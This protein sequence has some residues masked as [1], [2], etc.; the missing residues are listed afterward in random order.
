MA[1]GSIKIAIEV[2]GKEVKIASREL[3]KLEDAG[4]DSSKGIKAAE[5]SM[6]SLADS[7][8]DA[9]KNIKG[10]SDNLGGVS[11]NSKKASGDIKKFATALGLV[12]IGVAAFNTLKS[13]MDDAISRFDTLNKFPKV[14]Q[15]LGV[16][17]EDSERA[18]SKLSDGIDGLPTKL[19]EISSTA[20]RMYTS[21]GDMDKATDSALALNN[22]LLGSG[23]S[24]A[25]AQRGTEQYLKALQTGKMEMDT[26][27]SL[28]E[29]MD[30]GLIKIAEGFGFAGKSAKQ[31]LY[32]ALKSGTITMDE[33]NDKLIEVGTGTGIMA[34]LAKENSLGIATSLGNLRNAAARGIANII[35]SFNKLSKE[36]TGKDIAQNIDGLKNIVNASFKVIQNV[37]EGT[38][39]IVKGF[40]SAVSAVMPV[41]RALSP[42]LIGMGAAFAIH[43]VI[44]LTTAAITANTTAV[45]I[46][47]TAK[48]VYTVATNQLALAMTLAMAKQKLMTA[49]LV[50]YNKI[51]AIVTTAQAMLASGM[52][53]ASIATVG[54]SGAISILGT[55]IKV[56]L[57][58]VGWVTA[59]IGAL[60]GGVVALVK[61]F[62][63][64]AEAKRLNAETEKLAE[65]TDELNESINNSAEN[66]K[67]NQ[68]EM[69]ASAKANEEL[70]KKVEELAKKEN[71]SAGEKALLQSH[72]ESLN[73]SIEGLNLAYDEEANALNMSSKELQARVDLMKEQ[74]SGLAAQ[75][76]L[77]EIMKE[78]NE[79]QMQLEEINTLQ[80]EW[81]K[82][83]DEK[84]V[85]AGEAKDALE[86]L[87]EQ[88][89][90]L[91]ETL[92]QLT[93]QQEETEQQIVT[94]TEN[95]AAA[96]E[97]GNLRQITSYEE[98][99]ESQKEAFDSMKSAYDELVDNATNAFERMNEESKVTADEMIANLEHN[100]K[101][102]EQWGENVA[103]LYDWAGKEGHEGF[104]Q[105]LETMGPESAAELAVVA[106][107][108]DTELKR[109][110]ELMDKG[111]ETAT[112]SLKTALGD[113]FEDAVDTMVKFVDDGAK[114]MREQIKSSGFDEIGS[115]VPEGLVS[116]VEDGISD[117]EK[118]TE[119][120]ADKAVLSTKKK[121]K[122]KSPSRVYKEIG[123]HVTDGMVL[124]VSDGTKKVIRTM[125]NLALSMIKQYKNTPTQFNS[126]GKNAMAGLNQ[127]LLSG[128]A[129]VLSTARS[130]ANEIARTMQ[131]ALDIHSP[132]RV[133]KNKV[134]KWVPEG[135]ALGIKENAKS[136][137]REL[138]ALSTNML[139][140]STPE[141]A[142]GTSRMAYATG[143]GQFTNVFNNT[144]TSVAGAQTINVEAGDIYMDGYKVGKIQW[145]YVK[146][147]INRDNNIRESFR[148]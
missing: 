128:R 80:D 14:L 123:G 97:S 51:V 92:S 118:A 116:G 101:M 36:V 86:E 98:L 45:T 61:W 88:E 18:M 8:A 60:V 84:V 132:S 126:I 137:Y 106:D 141:Q 127:G 71:K 65:S 95:I 38:T 59:G 33:F 122:V 5:K 32:N 35:D 43:K 117:V 21:F 77:A 102:T 68:S 130:I 139:K 112:D 119:K 3:D 111:A 143:V 79:A 129:R 42:V 114:T 146:E 145:R 67:K 1:D 138:E 135:I 104:L 133:M 20:Q 4:I 44:A 46:A 109:F 73:G 134:G 27:N 54:L 30:V 75:E 136:V 39:P 31:D 113:G 90:A 99:S 93:V 142:L 108:S 49:A 28:S 48:K 34:K 11:D 144:T 6:D 7:S 9:G 16:S 125:Q 41:V 50:A 23:A 64:E 89:A 110:A 13:S 121:L 63:K 66:Y 17:A 96:I 24:A 25:D 85:K 52:S 26:W 37:I 10:A 82:K 100:Q 53:L 70:A 131:R 62:N 105:W 47:T 69:K 57:G 22:A 12:A 40:A 56:L 94:S 29:T 107:M 72:I 120:M 103:K 140:T 55:A 87:D 2:D 19:D 74:E 115:M 15:A 148:G 58:P 83:A 124:G 91:K 76:R 81:N 147:N 78:Q